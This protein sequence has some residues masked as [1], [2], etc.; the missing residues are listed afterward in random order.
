[1]VN[2]IQEIKE[3]KDMILETLAED[4]RSR[5]DDMWLILNIWRKQGI[6]IYIDYSQLKDLFNP[7]TIIR[8][9]AHIQN[10]EGQYLPTDPKILIKRKFKEELVKRF[11]AQDYT[12]L[13]EW[14]SLKY[15]VR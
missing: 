3:A 14:E 13:R 11:Y 15:G 6:K 8:A 7:E 5:N 9:R 12:M 10:V 1:M 4:T 2:P